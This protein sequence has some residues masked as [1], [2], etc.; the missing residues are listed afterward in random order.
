[1][2]K[3]PVCGRLLHN[4]VYSGWGAMYRCDTCGYERSATAR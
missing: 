4:I 1:M 2:L 3:C